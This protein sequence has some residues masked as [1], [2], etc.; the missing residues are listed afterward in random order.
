VTL[1]VAVP[2]LAAERIADV[3]FYPMRWG[4]IEHAAAQEV[5]VTPRGITLRAA[6]GA[7]PEAVEAPIDGVLVV[8]ERLDGPPAGR[9]TCREPTTTCAPRSRR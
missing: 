7:L 5:E 6:R 4:V 3:W 8:S 2:G 1:T 9:A